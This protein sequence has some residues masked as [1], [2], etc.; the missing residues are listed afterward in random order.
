MHTSRSALLIGAS[1]GLGL[2]LARQLHGRGWQLTATVRTAASAQALRDLPGIHIEQ[3][4]ID[5]LASV[6]ALQQRLADRQF[7]LLLVNAGISGPAHMS[8]DQAGKDELGQLFMTNA[9]APVRLAEHLLGHLTAQPTV[10]FMSSL[11]G[12]VS[13]N[14]GHYHALYKASKAALN[15]LSHGFYAAHQKRGLTV[16]SMHPG[17]VRTDMGG[18]AAPLDVQ[19]SCSGLAE[20]L[21]R[22][23]GC[24][25]HLFL[26]YQ[27]QALPW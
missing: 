13:L 19:T 18:D 6:T 17:W 2:G 22:Y 16:L 10:A 14:D 7:D 15:C 26:D 12:S 27:G 24:Q 20:T 23:M 25:Q 5:E 4:D 9:I 3:V 21:D 1:R 11:M 8:L